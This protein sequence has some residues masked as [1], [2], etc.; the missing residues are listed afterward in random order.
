MSVLVKPLPLQTALDVVTNNTG[1]ASMS[2]LDL[3]LQS[4]GIDNW[5]ENIKS[6]TNYTLPSTLDVNTNRLQSIKGNVI[7][8]AIN[9][10]MSEDANFYFLELDSVWI[11]STGFW[12]DTAVWKDNK[13]W[14]D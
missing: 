6:G 8:E 3:F 9:A 7:T 5:T 1:V 12:N 14:I 13:Y 4:N 11:L 2:N 10:Q